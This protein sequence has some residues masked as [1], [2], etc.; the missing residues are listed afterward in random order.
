MNCGENAFAHRARMAACAISLGRIVE[1]RQAAHFL[2][3]QAALAAQERI[4]LARVGIEL[5]GCLLE[6]LERQ[7]HALEGER[8]VGEH[9]LAEGRAK[10]R[11]IGGALH[12]G[13]HGLGARIGHLERREQR[14]SR[15]VVRGLRTSVPGAPARRSLI[16]AVVSIRIEVVFGE[17]RDVLCVHERGHCPHSGLRT[18]GARALHRQIICGPER[19]LGIVAACAGGSSRCRQALV[20]KQRPAHGAHR[21]GRRRR[22]KG[23]GVERSLR[24]EHRAAG[25]G[26]S[27]Q[28]NRDDGADQP[29]AHFNES[30]PRHP[31]PRRH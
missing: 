6:G 5:R 18:V 31:R 29:P 13:D 22:R 19:V 8:A 15:L 23:I 4:V 28:R 20:E 7:E 30:G 10:L 17:R 12:L 3:R 26:T 14:Q 9:A 11:R 21:R 1:R 27:G 16:H 2:G 24:R 25:S